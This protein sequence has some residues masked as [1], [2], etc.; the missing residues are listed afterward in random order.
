MSARNE[1]NSLASALQFLLSS[2]SASATENFLDEICDFAGG[3]YAVYHV[4]HGNR[5]IADC[6]VVK[7]N[8]PAAWVQRYLTRNYV[9]ID[10]VVQRGFTSALPFYWDELKL[11]SSSEVA[12]FREAIGHGI[13]LSG[14]SIPIIDKL[15]RRALF[16]ISSDRQPLEWRQYVAAK[17]PAIIDFAN[18]FHQKLQKCDSF[19]NYDGPHLSPRE[20]ECLSWVAAGKDTGS[21]AIILSLSEH[22]VRDYL[23]SAR[24]KLGCTTLAQAVHKATLARILPHESQSP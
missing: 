11:R 7:T 20:L 12:L 1:Q 17:L 4:A 9:N 16:S 15:G 21:I 19:A 3:K 14:V 24:Y 8:Y 5:T 10:P 6:P 2:E 18:G 23:K 13:G 22:T